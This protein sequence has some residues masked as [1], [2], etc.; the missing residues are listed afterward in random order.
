LYVMEHL[1]ESCVVEH[2]DWKSYDNFL[3]AIDQ[4]EKSS[5]PGYPFNR[6]APTIGEWLEFN[7]MTYN[8]I[9]VRVL[10]HAVNV[11]M[12]LDTIDCFWRCFIKKEPHNMTKKTSK[13]WRLI[14]CCP[15]DVQVLWQMVFAKQNN[16][17]IV[18]ALDIPSIQ[19]MRVPFGG[20]KL[21]YQKWI[22]LGT[23]TSADMTAWDWTMSDWMLDL[24][25]ELRRRLIRTDD[26]W[27]KQALK[28][29]QNAFVDCKLLLSNGRV[30]K[31]DYPGIMKSGCVNTISTNS[32]GQVMLHILYS[33]R[34]NISVA[35]VCFA[36]GDDTLRHP[37]HMEDPAFF[38]QFGCR[39][40][41]VS[42]TLEFLGRE[43]VDEG[44]KPMYTSKHLFKLM[45]QSD[46]LIE[47]TL[48]AYLREYVNTTTEYD[49]LYSLARALGL[50]SKVHSR[51]YYKFWLDNP[52]AEFY[53]VFDEY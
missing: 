28:L 46:D 43:W 13:R 48:D 6:A 26:D 14:S 4:L 40:K 19:G 47:E 11:L 17:E 53:N 16:A 41:T 20:W 34:K 45:T 50:E 30:F 24:D 9:Q 32:H 23:T 8:P 7:G 12:D 36:V 31:Q 39:I 49:F 18:G 5:S 42:D 38:E 29:Y 3:V 21:F 27:H 44:M 22:E 1:Y 10:W 2:W 37:K 25:L 51:E 35:P 33:L 15:L 52:L